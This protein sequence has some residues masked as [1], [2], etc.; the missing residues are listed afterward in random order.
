MIGDS[1][2]RRLL[3]AIEHLDDRADADRQAGL[4]QQLAGDRRFERFA[5]FHTATRQTP[6]PLER[7]VCALDEHHTLAGVQDHGAHADD[8]PF[9]KLPH[10]LTSERAKRQH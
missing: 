6:L 10:F 4:F 7:F 2:I 8:G 9:W 5:N 3:D 1:P